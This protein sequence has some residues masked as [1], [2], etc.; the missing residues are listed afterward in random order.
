MGELNIKALQEALNDVVNRH[1]PL[2]TIFPKVNG[3][4][5][6]HILQPNEMHVELKVSHI[7]KREVEE[8]IN[9]AVRYSFNLESEPAVRAQLF[10]L[11]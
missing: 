8:K 6:Q 3:E 4:S 1:E 9:E 10:A 7:N 11:D 2:R 5:Y